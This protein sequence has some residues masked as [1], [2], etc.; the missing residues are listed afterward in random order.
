MKEC[1]F[2]YAIY[3][4]VHLKLSIAPGVPEPEEIVRSLPRFL[5]LL[6]GAVLLSP[7]RRESISRSDNN[8]FRLV[9]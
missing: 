1:G 5:T 4:G 6:V 7:I 3:L 8:E 2:T 9:V